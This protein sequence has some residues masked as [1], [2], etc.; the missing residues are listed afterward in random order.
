MFTLIISYIFD[1]PRI[2]AQCC[3]QKLSKM[4][5][6]YSFEIPKNPISHLLSEQTL[7]HDKGDVFLLEEGELAGLLVDEVGDELDGLVKE[8]RGV[9]VRIRQDVDQCL[10]QVA[11]HD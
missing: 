3:T 6:L 7:E 9:V 8:R 10:G 11:F 5:F 2:I 4:Y 1:W